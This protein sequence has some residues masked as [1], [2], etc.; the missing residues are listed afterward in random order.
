[1]ISGSGTAEEQKVHK[2][3]PEKRKTYAYIY[4]KVDML[5]AYPPYYIIYR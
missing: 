4:N 2:T 3:F 1:L 5:A